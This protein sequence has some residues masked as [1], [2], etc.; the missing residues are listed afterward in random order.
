MMIMALPKMKKEKQAKENYLDLSIRRQNYTVQFDIFRKSTYTDT[1]IPYN[2]CHPKEHIYA[3]PKYLINRWKNYPISPEAKEHELTTLQS[4][5]YNNLFPSQT[6]QKLQKTKDKSNKIT[7]NTKQKWISFKFI[8]KESR[9]IANIFRNT[10]LRISYKT[11]NNIQHILQ[12]N[13]QNDSQNDKFRYSGVYQ[14]TC[15]ECNKKYIGQTREVSRK[16]FKN[17]SNHLEVIAVT[18]ISPSFC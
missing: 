11:R 9:S 12:H 18:Q 15:P 2:S 4:I 13:N 14:L 7:G 16:G 1:I 8:G 3:A 6:V 5:L 17:I 10:N